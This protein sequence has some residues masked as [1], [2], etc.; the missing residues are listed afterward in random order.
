MEI[1]VLEETNKT[2]V[3]EVRGEGHTLCN[4][5]KRELWN[6]K[7]VKTA[8]YS[9]KHPLI[10]IPEMTIETDGELKPRKAVME[11]SEKLMEETEKFSKE[12]KKLK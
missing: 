9:V 6:N 4:L 3:F 11:A 12:F 5:L 10:G 8:T 2:I 7:H 1:K